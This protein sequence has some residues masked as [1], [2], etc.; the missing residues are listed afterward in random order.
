MSIVGYSIASWDLLIIYLQKYPWLV[1]VAIFINILLGKW[2]GL[3]LSEFIRF[4][5]I[6]KNV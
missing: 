1:F 6:L 4:K 3:R 2:T 5:K